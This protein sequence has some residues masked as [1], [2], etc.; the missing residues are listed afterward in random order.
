M[1][2]SPVDDTP[3]QVQVRAAKRARLM[4]AG[5]PAYPVRLPITTNIKQV[6][7]K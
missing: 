1:T 4:D 7:E 5:I 3:E 2:D 6:R